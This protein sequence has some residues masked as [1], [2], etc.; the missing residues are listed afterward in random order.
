MSS[1]GPL[2]QFF[3]TLEFV[4]GLFKLVLER[5]DALGELSVLFL[6]VLNRLSECVNIDLTAFGKTTYPCRLRSGEVE[7]GMTRFLFCRH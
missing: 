5:V 3:E 2:S 7:R 6:A 1:G 4:L